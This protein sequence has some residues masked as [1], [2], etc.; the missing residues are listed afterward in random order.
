MQYLGVVANHQLF[1]VRITITQKLV[2]RIFRLRAVL[3]EIVDFVSVPR[4]ITIRYL[5]VGI[6]YQPAV[7]SATNSQQSIGLRSHHQRLLFLVL[8]SK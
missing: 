6:T 8:S 4:R 1:D 2:A 3:W 5:C 7:V